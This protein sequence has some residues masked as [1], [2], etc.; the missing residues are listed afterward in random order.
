MAI[1][2]GFGRHAD[3][4]AGIFCNIGL[5]EHDFG[6]TIKREDCIEIKSGDRPQVLS[7]RVGTDTTE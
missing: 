6:A 3:G 2:A 1:L 7:L 4:G 5:R